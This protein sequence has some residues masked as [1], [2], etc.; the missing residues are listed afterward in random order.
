MYKS[1]HP[2]QNTSVS[3]A[4]DNI[5]SH[6]PMYIGSTFTAICSPALTFEK[7]NRP[8]QLA[9]FLV[10]FK[11]I[12]KL[13]MSQMPA[14]S[15]VVIR[16]LFE[17]DQTSETDTHSDSRLHIAR[18]LTTHHPFKTLLCSSCQEHKRFFFQILTTMTMNV[19]L[20]SRN[21]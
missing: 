16:S 9:P 13:G 8:F 14:C 7:C 4:R 5:Y 12:M 1:N 18:H 2:I 21:M 20:I 15:Y 11:Q 3:H 6:V 19:A 17:E 10:T